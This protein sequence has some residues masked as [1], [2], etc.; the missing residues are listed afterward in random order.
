MDICNRHN[1]MNFNNNM[2]S[3]NNQHNMMNICI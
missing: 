2:V 1:K 3:T